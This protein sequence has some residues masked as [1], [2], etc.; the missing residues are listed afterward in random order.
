VARAALMMTWVTTPGLEMRDR[1]PALTLVMWALARLAMDSSKAA[2]DSLARAAHL[3]TDQAMTTFTGRSLL[4]LA[5]A[6]R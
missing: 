3:N 1:W 6:A 5:C 2:G 4:S